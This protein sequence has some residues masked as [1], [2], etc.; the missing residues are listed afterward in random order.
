MNKR[1]FLSRMQCQNFADFR[2]NHLFSVGDKN[3]VFQTTVP[4]T[5]RRRKKMKRM[6]RGKFL[7]CLGKALQAV[8]EIVLNNAQSREQKFS[9]KFFWPKFLKIP[10]GRGRPRLRVMDVRAQMLVFFQDLSALTEVL[11]R[12]IRAKDPRMSAGYPARKLPLWTDF[13]F[14][15]E[16]PKIKKLNLEMQD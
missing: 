5:P 11:A 10:S 4:T 16:G 14:L 2:Q 6:K 1:A 7:K 8:P 12:D 3:T 15:T 9:P 13:L